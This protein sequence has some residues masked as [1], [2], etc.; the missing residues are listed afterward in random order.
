MSRPWIFIVGTDFPFS[1][2]P[3]PP[4]HSRHPHRGNV[5]GS[6]LRK[7]FR[8]QGSAALGPEEAILGRVEEDVAGEGVMIQRRVNFLQGVDPSFLEDPP[9]LGGLRTGAGRSADTPSPDPSSSVAAA[10]PA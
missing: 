6:H 9:D 5:R 2:F 10:Q 3:Y 4:V 7:R 8:A 1:S